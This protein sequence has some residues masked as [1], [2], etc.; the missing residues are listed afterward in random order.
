MRKNTVKEKWRRGEIVYGAW[1]GIP[2]ALSAEI[3]ARQGY[4]YACVDMQH[5]AIDF[6]D[7]YDMIVAISGT[8]TMPFVRVPWNEFGII[9]K[10]LDAGAMGVIIPM[11]N[12]P[13]EAQACVRACRYA[14]EGAR[15]YGPT[16]A[17]MWAGDGYFEQA[18]AEIACIPM[19]ETREAVARL[20]EILAVE[21]IDAV[22][23]GPA[24]L[25]VSLGMTPG[26]RN[27][28]EWEAARVT[29]AEACGKYG[30]AAGMHAPDPSLY[31]FH[32]AA[33]YR[34]ITAMSDMVAL[35]EG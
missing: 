25:S 10:V 19:V 18:N 13:E 24:D 17:A 22:Y 30:I 7:A 21:G 14:P 12:T 28:G 35:T 8:E 16:R 11:V 31:R 33:G 23:V 29:I 20:D 15:S 9:N 2:S 3:V 34:M 5:G 27:P 6:A 26:L 4:D 32:E 1:L